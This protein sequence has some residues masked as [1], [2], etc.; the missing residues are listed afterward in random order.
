VLLERLAME[1]KDNIENLDAALQ[2][3]AEIDERYVKC[4]PELQRAT[5]NVKSKTIKGQG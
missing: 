5:L 3:L 4:T 2:V 1:Q